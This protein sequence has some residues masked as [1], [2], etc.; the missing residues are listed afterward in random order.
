MPFYADVAKIKNKHGKISEMSLKEYRLEKDKRGRDEG[1]ELISENV[2]DDPM[3]DMS[4][5]DEML[6]EEMFN[7]IKSYGLTPPVADRATTVLMRR[8]I[9]DYREKQ[10]GK[11][12]MKEAQS[13]RQELKEQEEK[14]ERILER[15][16]EDK[17][18]WAEAKKKAWAIAEA[19]NLEK[20]KDLK[21]A[22]LMKFINENK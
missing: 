14:E 15:E 20:P 5:V 10:L 16:I 18:T 9:R 21:L 22:S 4:D 1:W 19:K 6:D 8:I 2:L 12:L 13:K 3:L 7:L 11:K 17:L